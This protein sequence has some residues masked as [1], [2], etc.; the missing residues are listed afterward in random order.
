ME[1]ATGRFSGLSHVTD[2][3]S[4]EGVGPS[5]S[6]SADGELWA[7][8]TQEVE[9]EAAQDGEILGPVVLAVA[10]AILVEGDVGHPVQ[11]VLDRPVGAQGLGE[12][13][14]GEGAEQR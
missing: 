2:H 10:D 7:R 12:A 3:R 1:S 5:G 6:F 11:A 14:G 13:F 9:G 8:G 4:S